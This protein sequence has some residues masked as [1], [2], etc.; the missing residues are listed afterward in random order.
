MRRI[1]EDIERKYGEIPGETCIGRCV[2]HHR[3]GGE[4][5]VNARWTDLESDDYIKNLQIGECY[6]YHDCSGHGHG[7]RVREDRPSS[8]HRTPETVDW[9]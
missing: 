2:S 3:T 9:T 5:Q 8:A 4:F 1:R 6:I 7:I